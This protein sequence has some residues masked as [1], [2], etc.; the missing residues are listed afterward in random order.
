VRTLEH[1]NDGIQKRLGA[2]AKDRLLNRLAS[3]IE[4]RGTLEVLRKG[5]SASG[6]ISLERGVGQSIRVN[7]PEN[8]RL[9]FDHVVGDRLQE[10]IDSNFKF[11]KQITDD[12]EFAPRSF[13]AGSSRGIASARRPRPNQMLNTPTR[14][15]RS[16]IR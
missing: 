3:E 15:Q 9:T 5:V 8:A 10:M 2:E 12:P 11:Y 7:T 1:L 13:W 4:R 6:R 14:N 16:R